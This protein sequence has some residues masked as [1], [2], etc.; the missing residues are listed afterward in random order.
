MKWIVFTVA[1]AS[2][3]LVVA[4]AVAGATADSG[5]ASTARLRVMIS[6]KGRERPVPAGTFV[7]TG[8]AGLDSG[9]T[10]VTPAIEKVG[11]RDGQSFKVV[12]GTDHLTGKKGELI[13]RFTGVTV[14]VADAT[15]VEYGK[16]SIYTPFATGM[17][18]GWRGGGRWASTSKDGRYVVR[19]EGL[20]TR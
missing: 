16:W 6:E 13:V 12:H 17:Y 8:A 20:V 1:A 7:L 3:V 9:R 2:A 19:W 18:E 10:S 14:D 5:A 4:T 15:D 11:V